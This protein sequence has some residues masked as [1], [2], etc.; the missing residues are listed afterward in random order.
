M[1]R[2]KTIS[3]INNLLGVTD[4]TAVPRGTIVSLAIDDAYEYADG[5]SYL[6]KHG[7]ICKAG[8]RYI[9]AY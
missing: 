7:I 9:Y 4:Y 2:Q 8:D 3:K 5:L 1:K 6:L